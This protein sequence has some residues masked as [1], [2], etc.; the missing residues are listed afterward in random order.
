MPGKPPFYPQERDYSCVPACLRMVLAYNGIY[1]TE[2]DLIYACR[3]WPDGTEPSVLVE[4]AVGFGFSRTSEER[5]NISELSALIEE[6]LYPIVYVA[7]PTIHSVVV[8]AIT[9]M[10]EV[11]DPASEPGYCKIPLET[12]QDQWAAYRGLAVI[13][14]R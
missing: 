9:D 13:L 12:F 14:R 1:E 4:A 3:S 10:V 8:I 5:L 6:G 7:T 11:L 2:D